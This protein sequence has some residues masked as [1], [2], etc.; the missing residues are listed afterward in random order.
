S[1]VR[2]DPGAPGL[3]PGLVEQFGRSPQIRLSVQPITRTADGGLKV[4]DIAAHLA[5]NFTMTKANGDPDHDLPFGIGCFPRPKANVEAFKAIVADLVA[6]RD[7]LKNAEPSVTSARPLGVHPGLSNTNTAT[8]E[9]T[10]NQMKALLERHLS[11]GRLTF[12]T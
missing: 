10:R 9:N 11:S 7:S 6:L 4:Y 1:G 12:M 3:S 5:F 8:A 2:I